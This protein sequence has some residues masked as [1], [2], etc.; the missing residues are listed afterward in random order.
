MAQ[1]IKM[2]AT[3]PERHAFIPQ[4]PHGI[5]VDNQLLRALL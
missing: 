1:S 5:E 2:L 4:D 3:K